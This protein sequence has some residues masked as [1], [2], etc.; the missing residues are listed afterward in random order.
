MPTIVR[1]SISQQVYED[2]VIRI[3][4]REILPGTRLVV[5]TLRDEYNVSSTPIRDAL[6]LLYRYG[7]VEN[8]GNSR[9]AVITV[10]RKLV[11]DLI[12]WNYHMTLLGIQISLARGK[13]YT[14]C[15]LK[16]AVDAF[17]SCGEEDTPLSVRLYA[18]VWNTFVDYTGNECIARMADPLMGV[19]AVAFGDYTE[20]FPHESSVQVCQ[21][22]LQAFEENNM[23]LAIQAV[24]QVNECFRG[25]V[26]RHTFPSL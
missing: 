12:E 23:D 1:D 19:F 15:H 4:N 13:D 8:L 21:D 26:D 24:E 22:L 16:E 2:L 18:D 7:F 10:T 9:Y 17:L 3:R 25:Y 5:N 14:Y 6:S 11:E 20:V